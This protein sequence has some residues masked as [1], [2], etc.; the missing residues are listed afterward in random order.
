MR[1]VL[2]FLLELLFESSDTVTRMFE[3]ADGLK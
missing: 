2:G 1:D 3:H